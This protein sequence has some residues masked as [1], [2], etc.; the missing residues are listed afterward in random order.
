MFNAYDIDGDSLISKTDLANILFRISKHSDLDGP[1]LDIV[2]NDDFADNVLTKLFSIYNANSD[3][4]L[5]FAEFQL[6]ND[7]GK[8]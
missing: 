5:D 6:R 8:V 1:V 2:R 4:Y 7:P 3:E